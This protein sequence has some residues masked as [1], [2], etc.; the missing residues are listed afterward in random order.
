MRAE[1]GAGDGIEAITNTPG[2]KS[3]VYAHSDKG[4]GVWAVSG[5]TI[6]VRPHSGTGDGI[7]AST[8]ST[9]NK[10]AVFAHSDKGNGVWAVSSRRGRRAWSQYVWPGCGGLQ[11][12]K[13]CGVF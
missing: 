4:N 12:L 11:Y 6:G 1:S 3:A 13:L 5:S 9:T 8:N 2:G 10:S 7:E